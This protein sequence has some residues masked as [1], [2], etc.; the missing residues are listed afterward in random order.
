MDKLH[1]KYKIPQVIKDIESTPG[2]EGKIKDFRN[3]FIRFAALERMH[4]GPDIV[5]ELKCYHQRKRMYNWNV[6]KWYRIINIVFK[7][8]NYT[9]QYC[10]K[11]GEKLEA[12]HIIPFSKGGSD[13]LENLTTSC[14]K[15]NRSKRDKSVKEFLK[16]Q[17]I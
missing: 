17:N 10:G 3:S 12:D 14:R 4:F 9:C 16:I 1:S 6:K 7:R 2:M 15:C 13:D 5:D 11:V 8:D